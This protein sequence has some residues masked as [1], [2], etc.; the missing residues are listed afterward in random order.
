MPGCVP[1]ALPQ[2]PTARS[3]AM[4]Y[5]K[6]ERNAPTAVAAGVWRSR[7]ARGLAACAAALRR[8]TSEARWPGLWAPARKAALDLAAAVDSA[9]SVLN[10]GPYVVL[11]LQACVGRT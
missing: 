2:E 9:A 7:S 1:R 10:C 11:L 5:R 4:V 6:Y 8:R 3:V